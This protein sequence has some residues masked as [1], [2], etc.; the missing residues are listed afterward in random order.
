MY[1]ITFHHFYRTNGTFLLQKKYFIKNTKPKPFF[2]TSLYQEL[3]FW[4]LMEII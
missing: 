2:F 1:G 3:R 4:Q